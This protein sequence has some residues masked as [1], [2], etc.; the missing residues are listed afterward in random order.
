MRYHRLT[1]PDGRP[2]R[3]ESS[4]AAVWEGD[5]VFAPV[6]LVDADG[7][8]V[9]TGS[10][11][12]AMIDQSRRVSRSRPRSERL[13]T[14]LLVTDIVGSTGHAERLG[15]DEWRVLL[16]RHN[17]VV[18]RE[19]AARDG[20]E[21]KATGDGFLARFDSPAQAV[22]CALALRDAVPALGLEIRCGV[23]T[24]ECELHDGDLAGIAVHIATRLE[25]AA[26]A[27]E[28][29]VSG[30]VKDLATGSGLTFVDRGERELKGV[31]G[32]WR[33]YAAGV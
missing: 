14:T 8:A 6:R 28:V 27:G 2:L 4:G 24:G 30:T 16:D 31:P 32:T 10:G 19:L 9:A 22:R 13:L 1:P 15:D 26:E 33:L 18:R 17:D 25:G 23:H 29:L 5:I 12:A 21:V 20:I 11:T 7:A 3:A